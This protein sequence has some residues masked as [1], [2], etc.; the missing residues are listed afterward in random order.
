MEYLKEYFHK[1]R[2]LIF[3]ISLILLIDHFVFNGAFREK[4]KS[5]MDGLINRTEKQLKAKSDGGD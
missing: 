2:D 3:N 1:N 5:I 4:I